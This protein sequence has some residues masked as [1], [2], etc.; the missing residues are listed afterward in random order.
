MRQSTLCAKRYASRE[1][2]PRIRSPI[3]A[4]T[5]RS[6]PGRERHIR[7]L[8]LNQRRA[9]PAVAV[10]HRHDGRDA[11]ARLLS[12]DSVGDPYIVEPERIEQQA[13]LRRAGG[14]RHRGVACNL[15]A[16]E[17]ERARQPGRLVDPYARGDP[18]FL[19]CR[20]RDRRRRRFQ[21]L[22]LLAD[23]LR[24]VESARFETCETLRVECHAREVRYAEEI[25]KR[26][27]ARTHCRKREREAHERER[28]RERRPASE[29]LRNEAPRRRDRAGGVGALELLREFADG[30][31]RR[32]ERKSSLIE[33]PRL[34]IAAQS[35][36]RAMNDRAHV[37]FAQIHDLGDRAVRRAGP[38]FQREQSRGRARAA[39]RSAPRAVRDPKRV[40]CTS[41]GVVRAAGISAA[42]SSG[43]C[44]PMRAPMVGRDVAR[45]ADQ[46]G[47]EARKI[48]SIT[49]RAR[50][51][52][53][54]VCDV[55]SSA[56]AVSLRR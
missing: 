10:R 28:R 6:S 25:E 30:S 15:G 5:G 33:P 44:W 42:S 18:G 23:D 1:S 53:S 45:D 37:R 52:F 32:P 55:R 11:E 43:R 21:D 38:V 16:R 7:A 4:S 2:R 31:C 20:V 27:R 8:C 29:P 40:A 46:P 41:S 24:P 3:S 12:V 50:Q 22:D 26:L 9:Q 47:R 14:E 51:A 49:Y 48:A 34:P 36:H 35:L 56:A 39:A 17:R 13:K 19:R 54:N